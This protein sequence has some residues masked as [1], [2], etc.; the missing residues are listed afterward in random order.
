[1]RGSEMLPH[2]VDTNFMAVPYWEED[3]VRKTDLFVIKLG[4]KHRFGRVG[5]DYYT[6]W[7][8]KE[9]GAECQSTQREKDSVWCG[10]H[11]IEKTSIPAK[12]ILSRVVNWACK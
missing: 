4:D 8:H 11:C 2:L 9:D 12:N 3:G 7:S 1:M 5:E 10:S 6:V